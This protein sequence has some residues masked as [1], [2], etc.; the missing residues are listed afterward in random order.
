MRAIVQKLLAEDSVL[1]ATFEGR[2]V[3]STG[4]D[5]EEDQAAG[6]DRPFITHRLTGT[7]PG[8]SGRVSTVGLEIWVHDEPGSYARIDPAL[9][10]IKKIFKEAVQV[11]DPA[12][13]VWLM[14]ANFI[15]FSTDLYDDIRRTNTRMASFTLAGSGM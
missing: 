13:G 9:S 1:V 2:V 4:L 14:E 12:T 6:L 7:Y 5:G 11:F 10:R 15:Q 8:S 3:G